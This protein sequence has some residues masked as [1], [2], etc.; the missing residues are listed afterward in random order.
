MVNDQQSH[1]IRVAFFWQAATATSSFLATF[2]P[3]LGTVGQRFQL[4]YFR[5]CHIRDGRAQWRENEGNQ[6]KVGESTRLP[7]WFACSC[8]HQKQLR[9]VTEVVWKNSYVAIMSACES[10]A[11]SK[12]WVTAMT[13]RMLH[14]SKLVR[15]LFSLPEPSAKIQ[16]YIENTVKSYRDESTT[17]L[18][19]VI[20]QRR[21]I[22]VSVH[23]KFPSTKK[24]LHD[25]HLSFCFHWFVP[26]KLKPWGTT[27]SGTT[28][29][30]IARFRWV[31]LGRCA[32][33]TQRVHSHRE[34]VVADA[35]GRCVPAFNY[36]NSPL[37][38][39]FSGCHFPFQHQSF[40]RGIISLVYKKMLRTVAYYT[41]WLE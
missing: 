7:S 30:E 18:T 26:C 11:C 21:L 9:V 27:P 5:W 15:L 38:V 39:G 6:G 24:N 12:K 13:L 40:C 29:N 16:K 28:Q 17:Y 22:S 3:L 8:H 1:R 23:T 41:F 31:V 20:L 35:V 34:I 25:I 32:D 19:C 36:L 2:L 37:V 10:S 4:C 33:K 14:A